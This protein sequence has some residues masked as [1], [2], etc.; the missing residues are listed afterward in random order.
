MDLYFLE[1]DLS[2]ST[3]FSCDCHGEDNRNVFCAVT[4]SLSLNPAAAGLVD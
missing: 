2:T 4:H 1:M 3:S